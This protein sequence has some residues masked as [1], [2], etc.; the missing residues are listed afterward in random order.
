[1]LASVE[2][3]LRSVVETASFFF[4]IGCVFTR[5]VEPSDLNSAPGPGSGG[6]I[7][8]ISI[9]LNG[10]KDFEAGLTPLRTEA[11]PTHQCELPRCAYHHLLGNRKGPLK[12]T[13]KSMP[14]AM[15]LDLYPVP[16]NASAGVR[17]CTNF[18]GATERRIN[19]SRHTDS[20]ESELARSPRRVEFAIS[21]ASTLDTPTCP[22]YGRMS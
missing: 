6:K 21:N 4:R 20:P 13:S 19:T 5:C 16:A 17:T 12:R 10:D 22:V 9:C 11:Q 2:M 3:I 7:A 18:P 15:S 14:L 1:M 8:I